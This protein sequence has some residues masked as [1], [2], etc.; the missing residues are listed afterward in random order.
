MA[1]DVQQIGAVLERCDQVFI[2]DFVEHRQA[3]HLPLRGSAIFE[4]VLDFSPRCR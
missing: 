2:P 4:Q 3:G 1:I